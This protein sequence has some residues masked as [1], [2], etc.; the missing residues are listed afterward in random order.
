[1]QCRS[2]RKK[3]IVGGI[4]SDRP[5]SVIVIFL[6]RCRASFPAQ[7]IRSACAAS[8]EE[9]ETGAGGRGGPERQMTSLE[10]RCW[11]VRRLLIGSLRLMLVRMDEDGHDSPASWRMTVPCPFAPRVYLVTNVRSSYHPL[12]KTRHGHLSMIIVRLHFLPFLF[13]ASAFDGCAY[14]LRSAGLRLNMGVTHEAEP[15]KNGTS[16][17]DA[18]EREITTIF[19]IT[20]YVLLHFLVILKYQGSFPGT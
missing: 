3:K 7:A 17:V 10:A 13:F 19:A 8:T 2:R 12:S 4:N 15:F 6:V 20:I 5:S 1:M 18:A 16:L 9:P 11:S 14:A